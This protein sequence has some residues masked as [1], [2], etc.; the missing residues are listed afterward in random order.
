MKVQKPPSG[1]AGHG[2]A[3]VWLTKLVS[4]GWA[5]RKVGRYEWR[6]PCPRCGGE[7]RLRILRGPDGY[8]SGGEGSKTVFTKPLDVRCMGGCD[9]MDI[10][11]VLYPFQTQSRVTEVKGYRISRRGS[12]G[13]LP[14]TG[15]RSVATS[16][17]A[18][19]LTR[20]V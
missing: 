7:E 12:F 20:K 1:W 2:P 15:S 14:T 17:R 13:A 6:G 8:I 5:G 3:E 11:R 9:V 18:A 16:R 10:A 4:G 19:L